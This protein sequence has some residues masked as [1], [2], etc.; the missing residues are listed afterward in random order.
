MA[1]PRA[2]YTWEY[3]EGFCSNSK[4]KSKCKCYCL[5][6]RGR[7]LC[8]IHRLGIDGDALPSLLSDTATKGWDKPSEECKPQHLDTTKRP[9][10][11]WLWPAV[12]RRLSKGPR[13]HCCLP[14]ATKVGVLP[15]S[16]LSVDLIL[17]SAGLHGKSGR[18]CVKTRFRS[19]ILNS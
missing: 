5:W 13:G 11:A 8:W 10:I 2:R 18:D 3:K 7:E 15:I 1:C 9:G 19:E 14:Q 12:T 6:T 17:P 4:E 16:S